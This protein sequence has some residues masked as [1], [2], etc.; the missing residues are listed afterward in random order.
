MRED[1]VGI[2]QTVKELAVKP[3]TPANSTATASVK[4]VSQITTQHPPLQ[5]NTT[6]TTDSAPK[7]KPPAPDKVERSDPKIKI[8]YLE[9]QKFKENDDFDEMRIITVGLLREWPAKNMDD[10][11]VKVEITFFDQ[12]D[13]TKSIVPTRAITPTKPL[14]PTPWLQDTQT[15][16]TAAYVIPKG[17][18]KIS[19]QTAS[20]EQFYGFVVRV[21]Y[22]NILQNEDARPKN[23]LQY[24]SGTLR[25]P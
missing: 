7:P 16:V 24:S 6:N 5:V 14:K 10:N 3:P 9:Q 12:S 2:K 8:S 19:S 23:L 15:T 22:H 13:D 25:K 18:R 20:L 21:Y 4:Q 17:S 1:L 11:A